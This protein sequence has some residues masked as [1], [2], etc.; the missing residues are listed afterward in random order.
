MRELEKLHEPGT[1]SRAVFLSRH[2]QRT[3]GRRKDAAGILRQ[4]SGRLSRLR[5]LPDQREK[6]VASLQHY[7][8]EK[9]RLREHMTTFLVN[10]EPKDIIKGIRKERASVQTVTGNTTFTPSFPGTSETM[11]ASTGCRPEL[12]ELVTRD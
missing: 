4:E 1:Q 2:R 3:V 12:E 5:G 7:I 8:E 6:A 11:Q 9:L 10:K